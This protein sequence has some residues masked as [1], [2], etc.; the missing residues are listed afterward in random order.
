MYTPVSYTHLDVYKRQVSFTALKTIAGVV[1]PTFQ[2]ACR[3]LGLLEDDAHWDRTRE[4]ASISDSPN[5]IREL[6]AIML[7]FCHVAD[8]LKL[9][10]KYRDSLAE[11]V[12]K[13]ARRRPILSLIHI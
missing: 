8:P 6:F 5:K 4:E 3:A 9:W 2:A 1:Q 7:V 13:R 10:E 12:R 11:D